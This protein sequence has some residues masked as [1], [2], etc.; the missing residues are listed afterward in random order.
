MVGLATLGY[1]LGGMFLL[2]T[3]GRM[4]DYR[5]LDVVGLGMQMLGTILLT[6]SL[7]WPGPQMFATEVG[8]MTP[9]SKYPRL[10]IYVARV[11]LALYLLGALVAGR[12]MLRTT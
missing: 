5:W 10:W 6:V 12:E 11:G 3:E 4:F 8:G 9:T 1:F 2:G 7:W